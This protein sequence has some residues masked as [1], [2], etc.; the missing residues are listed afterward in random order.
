MNHDDEDDEVD[1]AETV[2]RW[3]RRICRVRWEVNT[4]MTKD[5]CAGL[6]GMVWCEVAWWVEWYRGYLLAYIYNYHYLLI[7]SLMK[8]RASQPTNDT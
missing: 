4:S 2:G 5:G 6:D 1:F 7:S 3:C 8:S